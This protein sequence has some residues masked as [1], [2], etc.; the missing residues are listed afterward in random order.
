MRH[1]FVDRLLQHERGELAVIVTACRTGKYFI[2]V[3]HWL[4]ASKDDGVLTSR[5]SRIITR[6]DF[7]SFVGHFGVLGSRYPRVYW[8]LH[9]FAPFWPPAVP[10]LPGKICSRA[11]A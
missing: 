8:A 3:F 10:F 11:R 5:F 1:G 6:V 2:L 7:K 9:L 4:Y